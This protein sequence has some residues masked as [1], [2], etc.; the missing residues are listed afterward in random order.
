[1]D[2]VMS[3]SL[4][5]FLSVFFAS[6]HFPKNSLHITH[7]LCSVLYSKIRNLTDKSE[8]PV[9]FGV[10]ML[11]RMYLFLRCLG[12]RRKE[13]ICFPFLCFYLYQDF[14]RFSIFETK[15]TG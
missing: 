2:T 9:F 1:M 3:V 5:A 6:V 11:L 12:V 13:N 10:D 15:Y 4:G 8:L 14:G 7:Y